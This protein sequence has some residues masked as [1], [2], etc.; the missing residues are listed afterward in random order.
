M[1][2]SILM[3]TTEA[4]RNRKQVLSSKFSYPPIW[5]QPP[6]PNQSKYNKDVSPF[7]PS[8]NPRPKSS[9]KSSDDEVHQISVVSRFN[10]CLPVYDTGAKLENV[11]DQYIS[12]RNPRSVYYLVCVAATLITRLH[13][14]KGEVA[15]AKN[16]VFRKFIEGLFHRLASEGPSPVDQEHFRP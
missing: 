10:P 4:I 5:A 1:W 15:T 7:Y 12:K 8:P 2:T 9:S 14:P 3:L 16:R 13:T 6:S 11:F